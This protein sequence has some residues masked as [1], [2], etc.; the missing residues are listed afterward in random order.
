MDDE[1]A[2]THWQEACRHAYHGL[3]AGE[4]EIVR[5]A[6]VEGDFC[7]ARWEP[8]ERYLW[9]RA[10]ILFEAF[11]AFS[12]RA[13][14]DHV[15]RPPRWQEPS[16]SPINDLRRR[17]EARRDALAKEGM[18]GWLGRELEQVFVETWETEVHTWAQ[19]CKNYALISVAPFW[20]SRVVLR[21]LHAPPPSSQV[22]P[23]MVREE[24][25]LPTGV[26]LAK[27]HWI[28]RRTRGES[29]YGWIAWCYEPGS[30]RTSTKPPVVE[31]LIQ[32]RTGDG[33]LNRFWRQYEAEHGWDVTPAERDLRHEQ[34]AQAPEELADLPEDEMSD[35]DFY[36]IASMEVP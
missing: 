19:I 22:Y 10:R 35:E 25:R 26:W 14:T 7:G 33:V 34:L 4:R 18:R 13:F 21:G 32:G 29:T 31:F 1:Q 16:T 8:G 9:L 2:K 20:L 30:R 12:P 15:H 6:V 23:L 5:V 28:H 27:A 36:A 3:T 17:Y 24:Q 11:E